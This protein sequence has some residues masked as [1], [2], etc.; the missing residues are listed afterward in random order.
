MVPGVTFREQLEDVETLNRMAL[1]NRLDLTKI[2]YHA[3]A[4]CARIMP[5]SVPAGRSAGAAGR[6]SSPGPGQRFPTW[7]MAPSPSR[8]GSRPRTCCFVFST[9]IKNV[10]VMP[11][12][13]IM[14]AG[15]KRSGHCRPHHPRKPLHLSALQ[16]GKTAR[17]RRVVE[18]HSGLPIPLGGILGRRSLGATSCSGSRR[19]YEE[20][21]EYAHAH[22]EQ[23]NG[24]L[25]HA[26]SG[27]GPRG[28]ES[29][30]SLYVNDFS[31]DLGQEGLTAV[32][33]LFHERKNAASFL[34]PERRSLLT[35]CNKPGHGS[36]RIRTDK[37]GF[38]YKR[39]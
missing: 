20:S 36:R 37:G 30:I 14:D 38:V 32:R 6:S 9:A 26:Q 22:P 34:R 3:L 29:H 13:R 31:L 12:D 33:R 1:E 16:T 25:R 19:A 7:S 27:D 18:Q 21:V 23:V 24:L 10:T 17:P 4:S 11:F 39:F 2:S 8:A 28:D 35:T 15:V 5:C